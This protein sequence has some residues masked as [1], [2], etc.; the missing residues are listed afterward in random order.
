M[1]VTVIF[2]GF[3]QMLFPRLPTKSQREGGVNLIMKIFN[4]ED[5]D[6]FGA[7]RLGSRCSGGFG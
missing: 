5:S 1:A 3:R 2:V 6:V 7:S 4:N